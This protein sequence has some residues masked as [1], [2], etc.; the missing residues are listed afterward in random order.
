MKKD[1][2]I[3]SKVFLGLIGII[4]VF[5]GIQLSFYLMSA[6]STI[7]NTIGMVLL[8][9]LITSVLIFIIKKVKSK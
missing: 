5:W 7:E 8:A 2:E 4:A 9:L 6:R 1:F 3:I